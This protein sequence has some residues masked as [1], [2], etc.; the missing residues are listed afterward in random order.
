MNWYRIAQQFP[1]HQR[2]EQDEGWIRND[3]YTD[4]GHTSES[5]S[6]LWDGKEF[7]SFKGKSHLFYPSAGRG[8]FADKVWRGW[9]DPETGIVSVVPPGNM[10]H[11]LNQFIGKDTKVPPFLERMLD[12]KFNPIDI[13]VF[14]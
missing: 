7:Q 14:V 3:N 4:V 10:A 9:Y 8:D 1:Y 13:K 5:I 12:R 11:K 2:F 6:W